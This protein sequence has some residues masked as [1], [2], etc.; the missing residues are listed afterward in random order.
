MAAFPDWVGPII[1]QIDFFSVIYIKLLI[2]DLKSDFYLDC[3]LFE[4]SPLI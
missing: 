3:L 4:I 1:K 2:I